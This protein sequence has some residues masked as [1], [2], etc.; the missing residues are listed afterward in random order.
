MALIERHVY[1]VA[2]EPHEFEMIHA[3]NY[4]TFVEEIPQHQRSDS[5]RLVDRFHAQNTYVICLGGR[6]L[7]G[8]VAVRGTRPFSLD[9]KL[10]DLD[11]YLPPD[12][13]V[14]EIRLLAVE[15]GYRC[16]SVFTGLVLRLLQLARARGFDVAVISGTVRQLKLYRHLGFEPF[17]P[18]VGTSGAQYQ[19]MMLTLERFEACVGPLFSS[20]KKEPPRFSFL[21]GPA[22]ISVEVQQRFGE[23][24]LSHRDELFSELLCEVRCKLLKLTR[25]HNVTLLLGS[26]TLANDVVAGQLSLWRR[27]GLILSNGEFGERL[28]DHATRWGLNFDVY[29]CP[30]G[31]PFEPQTLER[32]LQGT[33]WLWFVHCETSTGMLNDLTAITRMCQRFGVDACVDAISSLGTVECDLGDVALATGVSSK[34]F[35]AYPGLAMVFHR[36]APVRSAGCLPRY[37]DLGLYCQEG[38]RPF[39]HS[40]NLLAALSSALDCIDVRSAN[41]GEDAA[42]LRS[43][44]QAIGLGIVSPEAHASPAVMTLTLPAGVIGA[45]VA[46]QLAASGYSI[47]HASRY[48]LDR[49][50]IQI[51]L[52]G[53][54]PRDRLGEM[55][56]VLRRALRHTKGDL[57]AAPNKALSHG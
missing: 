3:L 11:S 1:K 7:I 2:T 54:Y 43:Q 55:M 5:R 18:L 14:C 39:T 56:S 16:T 34:G 10:P 27:R 29:R 33:S 37:L 12:R 15:P 30:W 40:S 48:L 32:R 36:D 53:D 20:P 19:P 46:K 41:L 44:T 49:N 47:A 9:E 45:D 22:A 38:G 50:W 52:M 24:P 6:T 42:F 23:R 25:A 4:R 26:G 28:I 17:G 35:G 57:R 51:A 13:T 21:P 31:R 8:M